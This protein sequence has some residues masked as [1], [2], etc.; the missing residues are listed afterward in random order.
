MKALTALSLT[1]AASIAL[2][3]AA[4][5]Q[6]GPRC[7]TNGTSA[8]ITAPHS[9]QFMQFGNGNLLGGNGSVT[10]NNYLNA[11]FYPFGNFVDGNNWYAIENIPMNE[12][13]ASGCFFV[14]DGQ[15]IAPT[16][17]SADMI[18]NTRSQY[19]AQGWLTPGTYGLGVGAV[20]PA[21][22]S[23]LTVSLQG[24]RLVATLPPTTESSQWVVQRNDSSPVVGRQAYGIEGLHNTATF[25]DMYRQFQVIYHDGT[26]F[27][28]V[29]M[30]VQGNQLVATLPSSAQTWQFY[31]IGQD[32]SEVFPQVGPAI[33]QGMTEYDGVPNT[34]WSGT[35]DNPGVTQQ[36]GYFWGR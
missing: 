7:T 10:V 17:V 19:A 36:L 15:L 6:A 28:T 12:K 4:E 24:N 11:E 31:G 16:G 14:Q 21:T 29:P 13:Q 22:T 8:T 27:G 32:G 26:N 1:A 5:A 23:R 25:L 30:T 2:G 33:E 20:G 9:G 35:S 18:E 3:G 34:V